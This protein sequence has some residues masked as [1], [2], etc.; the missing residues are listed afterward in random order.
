[1]NNILKENGEII[2]PLGKT[3]YSTCTETLIDKYGIGWGLIT[4]H[5]ER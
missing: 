3:T 4:E 1:M 5:T 2:I